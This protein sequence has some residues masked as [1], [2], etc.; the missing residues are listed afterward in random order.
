M[1][2][3]EIKKAPNLRCL[4]MTKVQSFDITLKEISNNLWNKKISFAIVGYFA[5]YSFKLRSKETLIL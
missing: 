5:K 2:I 4:G 3:I 1:I